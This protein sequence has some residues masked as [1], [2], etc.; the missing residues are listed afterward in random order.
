VHINLVT[1]KK[2][3]LW[4]TVRKTSNCGRQVTVKRL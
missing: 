1:G 3:I 4:C 2:S